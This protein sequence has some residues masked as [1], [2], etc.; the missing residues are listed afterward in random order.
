MAETDEHAAV[1]GEPRRLSKKRDR[2]LLKEAR[3]GSD[4]ALEALVAQ[5]WHRAHRIAY[6]ILGDP[7]IAEDVTQEAM[8]SVLANF[9][10]FDTRR[11]FE[12][13][14]HRIVANRALDWARA[15]ARQEE[16]SRLVAPPASAASPDPDLV[17]ALAGLTPDHRAVVVLRFVAGYGTGEI[18]RMLDI[19][20]G[21][22]GSR[23]RRGLDQLKTRLEDGDG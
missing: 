9:G 23:L 11:A 13:W 22:V 8:I 16:I 7:H 21:T 2:D 14:L 5:H 15:R 18:A 1:L 6:G 20:R 19:Q 17:A 3:R 4:E 10:R 12:P